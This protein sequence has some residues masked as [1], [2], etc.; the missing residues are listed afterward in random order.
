MVLK[1]RLNMLTQF[2]MFIEEEK[3]FYSM[4]RGTAFS[5]SLTLQCHHLKPIKMSA[6][7][8]KTTSLNFKSS[9]KAE[10]MFQSRI[11]FQK[12]QSSH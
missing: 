7:N 6:Q 8:R 3:K 9:W 4:R 10:K 1:L 11:S 12:Q 5:A 2:T